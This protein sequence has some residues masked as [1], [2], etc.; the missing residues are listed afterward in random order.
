MFAAQKIQENKAGAYSFLLILFAGLCLLALI[1]RW[2]FLLF[3]IL[4]EFFSISVAYS[5]FFYSWHSRKL[6]SSGFLLFI[7]VA[8]L[9]VGSM[10]LLHTIAY[11][12]MGIL[13]I[14]GANCATQLWIAS[15]YLEASS[16]L[17][18]FFFINRKVK[19]YAVF[20]GYSLL[21][22]LVFASIFILKIFPVCFIEGMG[23]T[24]FKKIS[25]VVISGILLG[26]LLLLFK[27]RKKLQ[28][29]IFNLFAIAILATIIAETLFIFYIDVY[30]ISN[31]AGHYFK[32]LSF[33]MIFQVF[34]KIGL[35]KPADL[36]FQDLRKKE[37][38]LSDALKNKEI[39][40]RKLEESVQE[41]QE[42]FRALFK[43]SPDLVANVDEEGR[44]LDINRVAQGYKKEDTLGRRVDEY[45]SEYDKVQFFYAM[46][47]AKET[48]TPAEYT[49]I[50]PNPNGGDQYWA[51]RVSYY[52]NS[53]GLDRYVINFTD[54]TEQMEYRKKIEYNSMLLDRIF[55]NSV[56][57]MVLLDR[58]FNF[59]KVSQSY[60]DC[61]QRASSEFEGKNLF[62]F[63]PTSFKEVFIEQRKTRQVYK[64]NQIQCNSPNHSSKKGAYWDISLVPIV[65]DQDVQLF[66]L[67]LKDV[68]K[69]VQSR[70]ALVE[71]NRKAQEN[72]EK[73]KTLFNHSNDAIGLSY[74][75]TNIVFNRM[76]LELFGYE[77][78]TEISGRSLLDQIA[79]EERGR[80]GDYIERRARGEEVPTHYETIG[81]R[82]DGST[83][84]FEIL[85]RS[86]TIQGETYTMAF[87]QDLEKRRRTEKEKKELEEQL[88]H[89][90]KMDS[91]GQLAGGI[92][93][94]Y[95]NMLSVILS[96]VQLLDSDFQ[97]SKEQ[98]N[99]LQL[100]QRAA[101]RSTE[102]THKLLTFG[103]KGPLEKKTIAFSIVFEEL[104]DILEK[105]VDKSIHLEF[106]D[107]SDSSHVSM[108]CSEIQ[109]AMLNL[110]INATHAMPKGGRLTLTLDN[111]WIIED[112]CKGA[113]FQ[114]KPGRHLRIRISDTGEGIPDDIR[115][116]IFDPYFTTKEQGKGSGLGLAMVHSIIMD[117]HGSIQVESRVGEG[118]CFEILL[119]LSSSQETA[120]PQEKSQERFLR[121]TILLVDD[122]PMIIESTSALLES[123]GIKVIR[124]SSAKEAIELYREQF[125][126]IDLVLLDFNMPDQN[127]IECFRT[128][129]D[130]N[131][132]IKAILI[133]GHFDHDKE[134][135][136]YKEGIQA[137]IPK[138]LHRRELFLCLESLLN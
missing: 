119:P 52:R 15:R 46:K 37:L 97:G 93:H 115:G 101:E 36:L 47:K 73:F 62:E 95:N 60:A 63:F 138:P 57:S 126:T 53:Q 29:S 86:I 41:N 131:P 128:L 65:D 132:S 10:D 34:T 103:R 58:D 74:Q 23:L 136:I 6:H 129:S 32:L 44:F 64:A 130:I 30:G 96:A 69:D 79:P 75:G 35:E 104:K 108:D 99:Y 94:D 121:G 125:S 20:W 80:I 18:S 17:L 76:Y 91:I 122:E 59:L 56:D 39:Q 38:F 67:G 77:N 51:N 13:N 106:K 105:T 49:P 78:E 1:S 134:A 124:A 68:S 27:N 71:A 135:D 33:V 92:A 54:V 4:V 5:V 21:F 19:S 81:L 48:G 87:L 107:Q 16:I 12:G 113:Y 114:L 111:Q 31:I 123:L 120:N 83:F 9:A 55:A 11:K 127:G 98:A 22:I 112:Q 45:L 137:F 89:R 43:N 72:E 82:K 100:I 3:H 85:V 8:Y 28:P 102:L 84:P 40:S 50:I 7:G 117:H 109:N 88:H 26:G 2:N 25:E 118:S 66:L 42:M 110:C 14:Q 24:A 116:R 133:S 70:N 90:M 61:C